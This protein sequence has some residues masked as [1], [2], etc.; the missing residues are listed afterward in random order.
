VYNNSILG[1]FCIELRDTFVKKRVFVLVW[2]AL[3]AGLIVGGCQ[4]AG[5]PESNIGGGTDS[6]NGR[7][8]IE[9]QS[10]PAGQA[11]SLQFTGVPTGTVTIGGTLVV[12]N[13]E[14]GTYTSTEVDPA[15]DFD[16]TAVDCDD[17]DSA[18]PSSGDPQTRT[19]VFNLDPAETVT[20]TFTN[21]RRG[22]LVIAGQT[23]PED[24]GGTLQFTGVPTGTISSNGTLVVSNLKP[25]TY[26]STEVDP[27]PEFDLTS[28]NCDDGAS[29]SASS[30]DAQ[31]RTAVFNLDPAEIVTCTFVN[32]RRGSLVIASQTIPE[33]AQGT[34]LFTGVP[35]GT[36]SSSGT[37]ITA[38]LTPGTYTSTQVDPGPDFELTSVDCDDGDSASPS[39]G[40]AQTRT[41]VFNL[42]PAETVTCTFVN[43]QPGADTN[44]TLAA[45]SAGSGG[46]PASGATPQGGNNPAPGANPFENPDID[47]SEFPLPDE[48]PPRAGEYAVPKAGPWSVTHFNGQMNCGQFSLAIPASPPESGTLEVQDNGMTI[49]GS[50]LQ[51]AQGVAVTMQADADIRGRY[52]GSFQ[53]QEQGVPVTINYFWQVVTDEY[54]VGYLTASV[55]SEGVTC[56]V[57]RP[58]ELV[59]SGS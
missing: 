11:G 39:N 6:G 10:D 33:G 15:P 49:I 38:N 50:G 28:V 44:S 32:T 53:G 34:F 8:V 37:L 25:G 47:L 12:S 54:I 22:S 48:L 2:V 40:D 13:L 56:T 36:I 17:G 30:G 16:L 4:I 23:V 19:A 42:D 5:G 14:P 31:T 20:C 51:D 21:T 52:T 7:L 45:G 24:S 1:P 43:A 18:S 58:Y 9:V 35:T 55:T 57:Y 46:A 27:A 41:A 3:L 59:Y 26:T 29:A